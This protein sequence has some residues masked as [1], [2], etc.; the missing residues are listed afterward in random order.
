MKGL[1][2]CLVLVAAIVVAAGCTKSVDDLME[3]AEQQR[4]DGRYQSAIADYRSVLED[5]PDHAEARFG[6]GEVAMIT[7]D[8]QGAEDA[9]IRAR[10]LGIEPERVQP[11]LANALLWQ[12]KPDQVLELITPDAVGDDAVRADLLAAR[13]AAHL[14]K[15]QPDQA[16]ALLDD[17]LA[18]DPRSSRALV[19]SA[20]LAEYAGD[21]EKAERI[22]K[23]AAEIHPESSAAWL[24][25]ADAV[26][27]LGRTEEA[28]DIFLKL[29]EMPV[30]DIAHAQY[31]NARGRLVESLLNTGRVDEAR[32]HNETMLSQSR[33]HPYAHYLAAVIAYGQDDDIR[34]ATDHLQRTLTAA[35]D[36]VSAK[37][38]MG[39]I[40]LRQEQYAQAVSLFQD[41]VAAQPD[42]V[43]ARVMLATALR[44]SGQNRQAI[45]VL[46]AGIRHASDDPAAMAALARAAGDDV[47]AIV[48]DLEEASRTDPDAR[49]ASM[50][51]AQALLDLE[52]PDMAL[53]MMQQVDADDPDEFARRQY[54]ALAAL[55]G[56]DTDRALAEARSLVDA[57]PDRA[58]AHIVLGGVNMVMERHAEAERSFQRARELDP[59]GS[60]P[61][62]NLGLLAQGRGELDKAA[63]LMEDGLERQPDNIPAMIRVADL[64]RQLGNYEAARGWLERAVEVE[65]ESAQANLALARFLLAH[66]EAVEALAAADR[67]V[68]A[69]PGNP[70]TLGVQGVA[71]LASE[72]PAG[73]VESLNAA[74]QI[75]PD[76][77]D[78][79]YHL[80]RAQSAAGD[81][82]AALATLEEL[83]EAHPTR[84]DAASAIAGIQ[85]RRDDSEAALRT[86]KR[87]QEV[88]GGEAQGAL[89]EGHAHSTRGDVDAA[90]D[91]Y[92]R[93]V[94]AGNA[95]ALGPLV[96]NR[97]EAGRDDPAEPLEAWIEANPDVPQARFALGNWYIQHGMYPRALPHYEALV[98]MS[99]RRNAVILN[100][101]A[102]IYHEVGDERA[103]ATAREAHALAPDSAAIT[104]TL[105]WIELQ[106]GNVR[107]AKALLATASE[108]LPD[109]P[110]IRYHYGA[111]LAE[112]GDT[113]AAR[114]ALNSALE[115][116]GD[117]EW[118]DDARALL[119]TL[120][121]NNEDR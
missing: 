112:A 107:K 102:W 66:G 71:R 114:E 37:L 29:V 116:G 101:L 108:A 14:Q 121:E 6:L 89:L 61:L 25:R 33:R 113:A 83:I 24:A 94:D 70:A 77:P 68:S 92:Q 87:M 13:A 67:A 51:L 26:R 42:N 109:N 23:E 91:A 10:R 73:A 21:L 4:A 44:A 7:G 52:S 96:A 30:T 58:A 90:I 46:T 120:E 81:D 86:A 16:R 65:P 43:Q 103:L 72:D 82:E 3:R 35:P 79:R 80:A 18:A 55:Q 22:A 63:R 41:V 1:K 105:G 110:Q 97:A 34:T 20:R 54:L 111:A 17:A 69:A 84:L 78:L 12:N 57:Y 56:G 119:H 100:N 32:A 47:D 60:Q 31:F 39:V 93:A 115:A 88:A 38:L 49:R 74:L 98:A 76:N 28:I 75:A 117:A 106:A 9:L 45:R 36:S 118:V 104:D 53:T 40:R 64:Q 11:P 15:D 5:D 59:D 99:D 48:A 27:Q 19:V 95:E 62:F 2:R 85:L 8:Y 50:G